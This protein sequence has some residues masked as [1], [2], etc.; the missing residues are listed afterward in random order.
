MNTTRLGLMDTSEGAGRATLSV[1]QVE[2]LADM[3]A[4]LRGL[5]DDAGLSTLAAILALAQVEA[6]QQCAARRKG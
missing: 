2:Y 4:E 6:A 3:I 5:A 1:D